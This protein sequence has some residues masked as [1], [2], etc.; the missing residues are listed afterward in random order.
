MRN[1]NEEGWREGLGDKFVIE[2]GTNLINE[3]KMLKFNKNETFIS[4]RICL[5]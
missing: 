3:Y 1:V 2:S 4:L 5:K